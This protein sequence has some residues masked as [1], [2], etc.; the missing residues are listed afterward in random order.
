MD[1]MCLVYRARH[2]WWPDGHWPPSSLVGPLSYSY[3]VARRGHQLF[4]PS[5][6]FLSRYSTKFSRI[7]GVFPVSW[8]QPFWTTAHVF[9]RRWRHRT[10]WFYPKNHHWASLPPNFGSAYQHWV[11]H[12][13]GRHCFLHV[14]LDLSRGSMWKTMKI[15]NIVW[16]Q[17][18][19]LLHYC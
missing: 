2:W 10:L 14:S 16:L 15:V 3:V 6:A 5:K 18:A 17:I 7:V 8:A 4:C 9:P 19:C 12:S 13:I 11:S 1:D